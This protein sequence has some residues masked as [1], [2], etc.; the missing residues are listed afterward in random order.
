MSHKKIKTQSTSLP[1][2]VIEEKKNFN[3]KIY[4]TGIFKYWNERKS[5][6]AKDLKW[7]ENSR[8]GPEISSK[9]AHEGTT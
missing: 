6:E 7:A 1:F 2:S 4:N 8:Q 9:G 5:L 3:L